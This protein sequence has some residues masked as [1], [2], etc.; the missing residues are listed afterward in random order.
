[1]GICIYS[2]NLFDFSQAMHRYYYYYYYLVPFTKLF[3]IH[4]H[5]LRNLRGSGHG[6]SPEHTI[7]IYIIARG[8]FALHRNYSLGFMHRSTIQTIETNQPTNQEQDWCETQQLHETI[9]LCNN[10]LRDGI[11]N[12]SEPTV[13]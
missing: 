6:Y 10:I 5:S 9:T 3:G 1:M 2:H 11:T 7:H 13:P 8:H 4:S 12:I